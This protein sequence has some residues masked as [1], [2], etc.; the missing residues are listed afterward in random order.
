MGAWTWTDY[1]NLTTFLKKLFEDENCVLRSVMKFSLML[2]NFNPDVTWLDEISEALKNTA[3]SLN[4]YVV[5]S[6]NL[7]IP[8][9]N[10][11]EGKDVFLEFVNFT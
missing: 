6:Q 7:P 2:I 4:D 10:A 5:F 11:L 1:K 3:T 8:I 9:K